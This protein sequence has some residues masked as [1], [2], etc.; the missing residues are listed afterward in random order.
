M[1][2]N[3]YP[4]GRWTQFAVAIAAKKS[5]NRL[6]QEPMAVGEQQTQLGRASG[7]ELF[8]PD[9]LDARAQ[10]RRDLVVA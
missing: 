2:P 6:L 3:P 8:R 10:L 1:N 4:Q 5:K 9:E 7:S